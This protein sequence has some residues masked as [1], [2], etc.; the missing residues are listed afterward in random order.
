M[1]LSPFLSRSLAVV[2]LLAAIGGIWSLIVEPVMTKYRLSAESMVQSEALIGRYLRIAKVRAPLEKQLATL[3][4]RGPS[5]GGYLEGASDTLA[6]AKL[7]NRVKGVVDASGGEIKSSQILPPRVDAHHRANNIR[8][9]LSADIA[10][11]QAIFHALESEN[12]FLF[13]DNVDVRRKRA[14]RRRNKPADDGRLTVRF[15]VSGY[16]R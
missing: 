13:L 7:Q 3:K 12:T 4:R 14:R 11:L 16:V 15:D 5:T 8:V 10:S 6:A 2:L 9:Q 1:T